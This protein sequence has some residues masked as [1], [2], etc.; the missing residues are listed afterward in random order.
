MATSVLIA[1][2][3]TSRPKGT[4]IIKGLQSTDGKFYT[5]LG[6]RNGK[7]KYTSDTY[8]RQRDAIRAVKDFAWD[9]NINLKSF[10][11]V[12][13]FDIVPKK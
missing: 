7:P 4:G 13:Q 3:S 1:E 9:F 6:S 8:T 2:P 12:D 11:F 10:K 5:T